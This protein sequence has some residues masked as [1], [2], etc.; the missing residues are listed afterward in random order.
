MCDV[1]FETV[2]EPNKTRIHNHV[3]NNFHLGNKKV[4]LFIDI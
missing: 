1:D 2:N 3:E 4:D